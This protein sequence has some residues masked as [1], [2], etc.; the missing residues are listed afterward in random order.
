MSPL[1]RLYT[2]AIAQVLVGLATLIV[3]T[4]VITDLSSGTTP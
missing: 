1:A 4:L 3:I 2:R